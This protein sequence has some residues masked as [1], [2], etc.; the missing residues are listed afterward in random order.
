MNKRLILL[1]IFLAFIISVFPVNKE[2]V[3]E[4]FNEYVNDYKSKESTIEEV[5]QLKSDLENLALY[6]FYK[7]Q[8]VGSVEKRES[9]TTMAELLSTHMNSLPEGYF[10]DYNKKIAY[11]AFL[12][13]VLSEISYAG[14][15]L[16]TIN[17]MPAYANSFSDYVN[18]AQ[19]RAAEVYKAWI[20]YALGLTNEKP[21]Q[22]PENLNKTDA[23]SQWNIEI[24]QIDRT[25]I[26]DVSGFTGE[27]L[28]QELNRIISKIS[29]NTY[30]PSSIFIKT[31]Q[32]RAKIAANNLPENM[33]EEAQKLFEYWIY[34]SFSLVDEAPGYPE[35]LPVNELNI[36]NFENPLQETKISYDKVINFLNNNPDV[37]TKVITNLRVQKMMIQREDFTPTKLIESDVE[38]EINKIKSTIAIQ[39]G[40]TKNEL[41]KMLINSRENKLNLHWLRFIGYIIIAILSVSYL[42]MLKKYFVPIIV[43]A[44]IV[45]IIFFA[46]LVT[47]VVNISIYSSFVLPLLIFTAIIYISKFLTRRKEKTILDFLALALVILIMIVPFMK[48]Y[49]SVPEIA[50]D[51]HPEFHESVYYETLKY[52]IFS[53]QNALLNREVDNLTSVIS[54]EF[55]ELRRAFG[56]LLGNTLNNLAQKSGSE[57]TISNNRMRVE[58]PSYSEYFSI[59]NH[60]EYIAQFNEL[61][62]RL[63]EFARTSMANYNEYLSII[64]QVIN[65]S[66]AIVKYSSS[67]LKEDFKNYLSEKLGDLPQYEESLADIRKSLEDEFNNDPKPGTVRAYSSVGFQGLL[68]GLMLFG[69]FT[70]LFKKPI[71]TIL[72]SAI[73]VIGLV[74]Y[75]LNADILNIF[76]HSNA[77]ILETQT[78]S[79]MSILFLILY[80]CIIVVSL[81]YAFTLYK[82]GRELT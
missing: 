53:S 19:Q 13:W 9:S 51:K 24:D 47:N 62:R 1:I 58:I 60:D 15:Q 35:Q 71:F 65:R 61:Q 37:M 6:R 50:L 34:R 28:L 82:K 25:S 81:I 14:F 33:R 26:K 40:H 73:L 69:P 12:A 31:V 72:I 57:I 78:N 39:M 22:Y 38:S 55:T 43:T 79:Y 27:T 70:V 42:K 41:S 17:E 29:S 23:F 2:I 80:S 66:E 7:I 48:L 75:L 63:K 52:D 5:I 76:V 77:P 30:K 36:Q 44:E 45:Y 49:N 20:I 10:D 46:N 74:F 21:S 8:M 4:Y 54:S 68:I 16:G 64:D 18:L 56:V 67:Y 11:S 59:K 3:L 32:E